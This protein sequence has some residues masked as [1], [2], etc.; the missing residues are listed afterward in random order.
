[1]ELKLE[2]PENQSEIRLG[3]Y[4]EF[5]KSLKANEDYE[6][7]H[8]IKMK[9]IQYFC[10]IP[11]LAVNK[12]GR[13][14]FEGVCRHLFEVLQQKDEFIDKFEIDGKRFGFIPNLD[15][16]SIGEYRDIN[17][18]MAGVSDHHKLMSV[19]FRPITV[20]KKGGYLIEEYEGSERYG[21][22]MRD[23]PLSA[24]KGALVFFWTLGKQLLSVTPRY[25][26]QLIGRD[27]KAAA[28][29]E[30]NGVGTSTFLNLLDS[31]LLELR[32]HLDSMSI[33][34]TISLPS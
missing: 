34:H 2:I 26:E 32:R 8:F 20:E 1:M 23:S 29:L 30:K 15:K 9:A 6:D 19:L 24:C 25:I 7:E 28:A 5:F 14:D 21:E 27:K 17:K 11:L 12:M 4:Q 33:L 22:L 10:H 31:T 18:Y 3:D 13:N 16:M